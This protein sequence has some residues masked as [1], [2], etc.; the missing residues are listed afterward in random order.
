[1]VISLA[2]ENDCQDYYPLSTE[3]TFKVTTDMLISCLSC[4]LLQDGLTM[5]QLVVKTPY[6]Q[7][8]VTHYHFTKWEDHKVLTKPEDLKAY[9]KMV[10]TAVSF[11]QTETTDKL[12]VHCR[13]GMGRTG[14][15]VNLINCLL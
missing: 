5:R 12:L 2:V 9:L 1:M 10:N 6:Q 13:A 8:E 15:T 11:L 7:V 14:A 3:Q 4:T